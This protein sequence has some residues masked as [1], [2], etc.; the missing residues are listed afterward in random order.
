MKISSFF[1]VLVLAM[2]TAF[3]PVNWP[4]SAYAE[5]ETKQADKDQADQ[6]ADPGWPMVIAKDGNELTIHQPQIDYWKDYKDLAFRA[7]IAVKP[8]KSKQEKFGV[9]EIEADTVTDHESRVVA[10]IS[11][12]REIRFPNT[13]EAESAALIKIVNELSPQRK[14][15]T[16]SLDRILAYLDPQNQTQ[17]HQVDVNLDPP[18][19]FHSSKPAILVLFMGKPQL[20]P[21]IKDKPDLMFAVNTNW[22]VFYEASE[23]KYYLLNVDSWLTTT[24][25]SSGVW[26]AAGSLPADLSSLP[27]NENWTD[28]KKNIPGKT[29]KVIPVV[30][31]S[32]EPAE[33]ILT[34]G[35]PSF[36]PVKTTKLMRVE[37][38][39]SVIFLNSGDG[40][41]YL[42]T[43]G[44]WFRAASLDGPWSA[45]SKD[46]PSDFSKIP[47]DD[48]SSFVKASI[49]GTTEA[50]D[51]VLLASV[52]ST[53]SVKK[54]DP[55]KAE[56]T[57]NGEPSFK[58]IEG[59]SVQYAVN[60]PNT[61]FIVSGVYYCCENGVWLSSSGPNGP[62][63]YCTNVPKEIYSI[64]PSHPAH[65]V[66][67]VT[68]QNSTPENVT[69][70]Q[71]SGYSGEYVAA[72]GVLMFGAGM[73]IGS[74]L[75]D[76]DDHYYYPPYPAYYS[77][78][79]GARYSYAYG[80]YYRAASVT[81][82]PYGG[83]GAAARYNPY[84]GTYSRGA[85]VYGPAGSATVRQAYNP[86]T[87]ARAG[88]RTVN[89]AYGSAG[90]GAAYNPSTGNA[91]RGGYKNT[92]YGSSSWYQTN[93]GTGAV[94]WDNASGSGAIAKTGQG[95]VYAGKDG[96]VYK[97]DD[98][99]NWSK[100]S[101]SGW[102]D[103]DRSRSQAKAT[104]QSNQGAASRQDIKKPETMGDSAT[105]QQKQSRLSSVKTRDV[106]AEQPR[107]TNRMDS[108][109]QRSSRETSDSLDSQAMAR[110][111]GNQLTQRTSVERSSS[112]SLGGG[113][114]A[115]GGRLR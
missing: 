5:Q 74:M 80:G 15:M 68:V 105:K 93:R 14:A 19:I 67:Y 54:A 111:R 92:P 110:Q 69:Y 17:Q 64:P 38:T 18:K 26:T 6:P 104:T 37:N 58:P 35:D 42:L 83:A 31:Y 63:A 29:A 28:V 59:T 65:N 44:R 85:Y 79:C 99:G 30:F 51:A 7:A 56:I 11:K 43:A 107:P 25:P 40:K 103:V 52:P 1:V 70:S 62:W 50:K 101:G 84:T 78:G 57:Y 94:K 73:I 55:V 112:R 71:T 33:L 72:T 88:A 87:G 2:I 4:L 96:T 61:I 115:S 39:E 8:S 10:L 102:E 20:K 3:I 89:T 100:N 76:H 60:S 108:S 27:E 97:K 109:S 77:Y 53:V 75:D 66:T 23:Q 106:S 86:Y 114:R 12:K 81:Y 46:L 24:D 13:S 49:P 9:I 91:V 36:T 16:I 82:G 98:S 22:D 113:G 41:Y 45:A 32:S 21:V 90:R 48:P 47:D 95:N 34:D